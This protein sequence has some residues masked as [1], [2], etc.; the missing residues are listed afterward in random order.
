MSTTTP[1][2]IDAEVCTTFLQ[3]LEHDAAQTALADV[4]AEDQNTLHMLE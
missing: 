4:F 2:R 3:A 1:E